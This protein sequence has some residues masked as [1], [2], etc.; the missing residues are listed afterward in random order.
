MHLVKIFYAMS[1]PFHQQMISG[2][3]VGKFGI[4]NPFHIEILSN[5][6]LQTTSLQTTKLVKWTITYK[7]KIYPPIIIMII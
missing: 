1:L 4:W 3:I 7:F 2:H 6:K 5:S